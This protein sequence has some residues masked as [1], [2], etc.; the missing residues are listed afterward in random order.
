VVALQ[1]IPDEIVKTNSLDFLLDETSIN[2]KHFISNPLDQLR[3]GKGEKM[4]LIQS[5]IIDKDSIEIDFDE[6]YKE[7]AM[8]FKNSN[9]IRQYHLTVD[10]RN[11]DF[12]NLLLDDIL[13]IL[14]SL[15]KRLHTKNYA[16]F[17]FH[18]IQK[19]CISNPIISKIKLE[20]K[21]L[22]TSLNAELSPYYFW[23]LLTLYEYKDG[24]PLP[25]PAMDQLRYLFCAAATL[26]TKL[27]N[28][29]YLKSFLS[30]FWHVFYE[31][32]T[33]LNTKLIKINRTIP[34]LSELLK[35]NQ[36]VTTCLLPKD[37]VSVTSP[38]NDPGNLT[39]REFVEVNY[40]E[41]ADDATAEMI[42]T[43]CNRL[44]NDGSYDWILQLCQRIESYGIAFSSNP[45]IAMMRALL[46]RRK[47]SKCLSLYQSLSEKLASRNFDYYM[48]SFALM[49][50]KSPKSFNN[51]LHEYLNNGFQMDSRFFNEMVNIACDA[52]K[53]SKIVLEELLNVIESR[54]AKLTISTLNRVCKRLIS[55]REYTLIIR[56]CEWAT[57][58]GTFLTSES[59][60]YLILSCY[61]KQLHDKVISNYELA[62]RVYNSKEIVLANHLKYV[63]SLLV[64]GKSKIAGEIMCQI[65]I[66][67]V[68]TYS[69][70]LEQCKEM[71]QRRQQYLKLFSN[72]LV[73]EY[74]ITDVI[75]SCLTEKRKL[76]DLTLNDPRFTKDLASMYLFAMLYAGTYSVFTS[77]Y[78]VF[79]EKFGMPFYSFHSLILQNHYRDYNIHKLGI[80]LQSLI[81]CLRLDG[82][83]AKEK[84][85]ED[86]RKI[87]ATYPMLF[88]DSRE[89]KPIEPKGPTSV[90]SLGQHLILAMSFHRRMESYEIKDISLENPDDLVKVCQ[91]GFSIIQKISH[92]ESILMNSFEPRGTPK[93]I[94]VVDLGKNQ[95]WYDDFVEE[96]E[97]E[98]KTKTRLK[99]MD[100]EDK[101]LI[102]VVFQKLLNCGK[103]NLMEELASNEEARDNFIIYFSVH[104]NPS[105]FRST[106]EKVTQTEVQVIGYGKLNDRVKV[107]ELLKKDELKEHGGHMM[108]VLY[109]RGMHLEAEKLGRMLD[110]NNQDDLY[111]R[112][113]LCALIE[114]NH[115]LPFIERLNDCYHQLS[116]S[117][118]QH[119][120]LV[121]G[122]NH[123]GNIS[124]GI[125]RYRGNVKRD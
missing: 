100:L 60:N 27:D 58:K 56:Y 7:L 108:R 34:D 2:P 39:S 71:S 93:D 91:K 41:M 42:N 28:I 112:Y 63:R 38:I 62:K 68:K 55:E 101:N 87:S 90:Y 6:S 84:V 102:V 122:A 70:K 86:K 3:V 89:A 15:S 111:Y 30:L 8:E 47:N 107:N 113:Y 46:A 43:V 117:S 49:F 66:D 103:F 52:T 31:P 35:S 10:V 97:D 21:W 94:N 98:E 4:Q 92:R 105:L 13:L 36:T 75:L 29:E 81:K 99:E 53:S 82:N 80:V 20:N 65:P 79:T 123:Y 77:N 59:Y 1:G 44:L 85:I 37:I 57:K 106:L 74:R 19:C 51:M 25:S 76:P 26:L 95:K 116:E 45:Q 115:T 121:L 22:Q 32:T 72:D 50:E 18:I 17:V 104:S 69:R 120:L 9:I 48:I 12:S 125:I 33:R 61:E 11:G 67:V 40:S 110:F 114:N 14:N 109:W 24:E 64:S 23:K 78:L 96:I 119:I 16:A 124:R 5:P 73:F 88:K 83:E 118:I 54:D